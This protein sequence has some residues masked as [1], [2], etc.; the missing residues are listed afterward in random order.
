MRCLWSLSN[1]SARPRCKAEEKVMTEHKP[2]VKVDSHSHLGKLKLIY[3]LETSGIWTE[4]S[5]IWARQLEDV[6]L[7]FRPYALKGKF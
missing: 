7:L 3:L 1:I 2:C 6:W 4:N 5:R